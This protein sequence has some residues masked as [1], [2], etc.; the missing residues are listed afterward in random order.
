MTPKPKLAL[1]SSLILLTGSLS[2]S[3]VAYWNFDEGN[4]GQF[5]SENAADDLSGNGYSMSGF[6]TTFGPAY[7]A[8]GDTPS[9]TG[10]SLD[11]MSGGRDGYTTAAGINNWEPEQWTIEATVALD[12][13]NGFLTVIGRDGSS[14]GGALSDFYLQRHAGANSWRIDF[15][16]AGGQRV[17]MD[18]G[19]APTTGTY[20]QLAITSDG[21]NS[22]FYVNDLS[23]NAGYVE[24]GSVALTGADAAANALASNG[25]AWTFGRGWYNGAFVDHMDGRIDEIRFSDTALSPSQFIAVPEPASTLLFG[26]AALGLIQRRR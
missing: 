21:V 1:A 3:T 20:Y 15:S 13:V 7:S 22:R 14:F 23:G 4:P 9:G 6:N 16:T 25:A 19:I 2:A 26:L 11:T 12:N 5:F 8:T 10:L 17:T 24:V 18:A